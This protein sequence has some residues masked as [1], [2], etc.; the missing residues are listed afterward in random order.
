M[1]EYNKDIADLY[2]KVPGDTVWVNRL[3]YA[4]KWHLKP[5]NF[6][7]SDSTFS[8]LQF[9]RSGEDITEIS[10][11]GI[12]YEKKGE[13]LWIHDESYTIEA[14]TDGYLW[15]SKYGDW[16]TYD[17][18][19]RLISMGNR[20]GTVGYILY[21][22]GENGR[23]IGYAD[24]DETQ[25]LWFEYNEDNLVSAVRDIDNRRVE[26]TYT[27]NLLTGVKDVLGY[28]TEYKYDSE[29][30]LIKTIDPEGRVSIVKYDADGDVIANVDI[31]GVGWFFEYD[32]LK[33]TNEYYAT[34]R[35]SSGKIEEVWY[36]RN[37]KTRRVDVNG[38]T[39]KRILKDDR[40]LLITDKA[41]NTTQYKK[42]EWG[43]V[44]EIVYADGSTAYFRYDPEF[45]RVTRYV[46]RD[47]IVALYEYDQIGGN[48]L[49]Q[50]EAAGTPDERIIEFETVYDTNPY[51]T[52]LVKWIGDNN[53]VEAVT[54]T[55]YDANG[56]VA[57]IIDAEG[58]VTT[59]TYDN[60]GNM[61]T[62]VDGRGHLWTYTYNEKGWLKTAE[63]PLHETKEYFYDGVGNLVRE[64]D[65]QGKEKIY[66]YDES[67]NLVRVIF[68]NDPDIADDDIVT[69]FEYD[70]AGNTTKVIDPEGRK[71]HFEYDLED[72]LVKTIDGNN[73]ETMFVY[74]TDEVV[75][76]SSCTGRAEQPVKIIYSTF[77]KQFVYDRRH[78]VIETVE[79]SSEGEVLT[80]RRVN[81]LDGKSKL[82]VDKE[83]N[84]TLYQNDNLDRLVSVKDA[85]GNETNYTYDQRDNLI[86]LTDAE[87]HTTR[88]EYDANNRMVKEIRPLGGTTRYDYDAA[89]NLVEKIDAKNQKAEYEYDDTGRLDE[90]RYYAASSDISPTKTVVYDYDMVG[91][92]TSY[93]D[94][95]TSAVYSYDAL[96]RKIGETVNYGTFSQQ[97]TYTY[98]DNGLIKTYTGPDA[99]AY[100]YMYDSNNQLTAVQIP[101]AGYATISGYHWLRPTA[102]LLPG[103]GSREFEYDPLMRV[104]QI[105]SKDP[106][107]NPLLKYVYTYD[108]MDNITAKTTEHGDYEYSYDEL[109]RLT[110]VDNPVQSDEVFTYDGVG[111]RLTS[112]NTS[113]EWGYNE[114]NGLTG[115][116]D[117]IFDYD[118]NGNMIEKN[119]GG[120][121]TRFFYNIEDRLERVENG[122]GQVIAE[123]YYDPFGRRLWKDVAGVRTCYHYSDEG[124]VGE[125]DA[126]GSAIKTYG[127][128]PGSTW[129][130]DP[131]FMKVGS[132]YYFYH[133]DHLGTPQMLT[134]TN[135]SV[136]WNA[137]YGSFGEASVEV[138]TLTNNLRF[139]GQF[140]DQETGLHYN[141][142]RYYDPDIGRYLS[143]DPIGFEGGINLFAYVQN[144]PV[145]FV[146]PE[147]KFAIFTGLRIIGSA[148][149]QVVN[150]IFAKKTDKNST[151]QWMDEGTYWDHINEIEDM[152]K[153]LDKL[154]D[155]LSKLIEDLNLEKDN[156]P[157]Q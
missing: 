148:M 113:T 79:L 56:N 150:P 147:G 100:G 3:Y 120:V 123:Y 119:A 36:D 143:L 131:L 145:N 92:L 98:Y 14:S 35:Y 9:E 68:V 156:S 72:R 106:A 149:W 33:N 127:Y 135:G 39:V 141:Y 71:T 112:A 28:E 132:E 83:G 59:Y 81:Y 109:Y 144:D 22:S 70:L 30:R 116:D 107:G 105:T 115:Y 130:T 103:G 74:E 104:E 102:L 146:D 73:N 154:N 61:L 96:Y 97:D 50:V 46:D 27:N 63:S 34:I 118:E 101:D 42:D 24:R 111:N 49:K 129:S 31:N 85:L 1:R 26:Y 62:M 80:T 54:K 13:G 4:N 82:V 99:I 117:I 76:C 152:H 114:N 157:C 64:M 32:Y 20:R 12:I 11:N 41:G 57:S 88:F 17:Q 121:V 5:I 53:T 67:Y 86:S 75:G 140:F 124:L 37:G 38:E 91:N 40:T 55:E 95:I 47:G 25:V 108:S 136:V 2:I 6:D 21:E 133:N 78:R 23:L 65:A 110:D 45:N 142:H 125:Y 126:T 66:E 7:M 151:Q 15:K 93:D 44:I 29:G 18:F 134:A 52:G 43:N 138:G 19:G 60:M 77:E 128:K 155:E 10:K 69:T 153:Q 122:S 139:A 8:I 87:N 84:S 137:T 58:V 16:H 89:G 51:G 94:G 48:L 90:I